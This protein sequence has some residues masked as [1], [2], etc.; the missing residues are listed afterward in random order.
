M[1]TDTQGGQT[2]IEIQPANPEGSVCALLQSRICLGTARLR[3]LPCTLLSGR[4]LDSASGPA[5]ISAGSS[6]VW[7]G[8]VGAG[9]PIGLTA[10]SS[11]TVTSSTITA[12]AGSM[13]A[14]LMAA[15]LMAG[16]SVAAGLMAVGSMA[17]PLGRI[18]RS[19][20]WAWRTPIEPWPAGLAA[21]SGDAGIFAAPL[22]LS[23][24]GMPA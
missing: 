5:S 21:T 16:A 11:R 14:G 6:V 1:A 13:A 24:A 7:D 23:A 10:R 9:A 12:F 3:I 17:A 15:G 22:L 4:V 18:I 2:A 19:T 8:A 20:V